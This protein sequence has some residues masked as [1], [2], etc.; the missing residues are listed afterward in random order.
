MHHLFLRQNPADGAAVNSLFIGDAA[1]GFAGDEAGQ[2]ALPNGTG[3]YK[4]RSAGLF[5]RVLLQTVA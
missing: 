1:I 5:W 2:H 3:I 4:T